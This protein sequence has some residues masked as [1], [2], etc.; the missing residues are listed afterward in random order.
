MCEEL[1]YKNQFNKLGRSIRL[2]Q[3]K[4]KVLCDLKM[5]LLEHVLLWDY[6]QTMGKV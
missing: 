3:I 5:M 2:N 4:T 1:Q 6:N